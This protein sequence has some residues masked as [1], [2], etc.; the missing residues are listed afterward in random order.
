MVNENMRPMENNML[1]MCRAIHVPQV[2]SVMPKAHVEYS[3]LPNFADTQAY[4][5]STPALGAGFLE[6]ELEMQPGGKTRQA[7]SSDVEHFLFVI[8]GGIEMT[9][10]STRHDMGKGGYAWVPPNT[11][12]ALNNQSGGVSRV[13]W[14]RK[15]YEKVSEWAVPDPVISNEKDVPAIQM[16]AE[17]EQRLLPFEKNQGFDLAMNILSFKPGVTFGATE[18]HV[19][20]HGAFFLTGR[21][22][23]WINGKH[24]EVHVDDFVYFYP[25][26]PHYVGAYGPETLSYILY[27]DVNRDYEHL[28]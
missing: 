14:L 1:S 22:T 12:L 11:P 21:G 28:I 5:Y 24:Y 4:I 7:L 19:F 10:E 8:D 2:V 26:V 13:L 17:I 3:F 25:F 9:L 20:E 23:F 18:Y 15:H 16:V 6:Y 27:K